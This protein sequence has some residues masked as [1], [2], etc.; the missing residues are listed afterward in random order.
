M[1]MLL[2]VCASCE[3]IYKTDTMAECPLCQ[4]GH[5][6]AHY[7]YGRRAYKYLKTQK[8]WKDKKLMEYMRWLDTTVELTQSGA[9]V[10]RIHTTVVKADMMHKVHIDDL[11]KSQYRRRTNRE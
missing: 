9:G 8:P 5:Y 6:S 2:R 7:V 4:F 3:W 11:I 1:R 10:N